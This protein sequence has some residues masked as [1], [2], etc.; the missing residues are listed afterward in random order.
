MTHP[1][2]RSKNLLRQVSS[3]T[4]ELHW[5]STRRATLARETVS[6][7]GNESGAILILALVF[8]I[9]VTFSIFGLITFGGVGI[10]NT[11][12]LK[13]QRALEYAA[14]GATTAA[15]QTVRYSYLSF[16]AYP[17]IDCLPD[18]A[19]LSAPDSVTMTI[20]SEQMVVDCSST[21]LPSNLSPR[22]Q[23][24]V[25]AF[26]ACTTSQLTTGPEPYCFAGNSIVTATVDFQDVSNGGVYDCSNINTATCGTGESI[27]SWVVQTADN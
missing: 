26:Y 8:V 21:S 25:I 12:G 16:N 5:P 2:R 7:E 1:A 19:V 3:T 23:D 6:D 9:I 22:P 20:N 10:K 17:P 24:R 4:S 27:V 18:G 15:I 14:D 11:V 13:S